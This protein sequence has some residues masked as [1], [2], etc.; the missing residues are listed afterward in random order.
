MNPTEKRFFGNY[1]YWNWRYDQ[2]FSIW[3]FFHSFFAKKPAVQTVPFQDSSPAAPK[4]N[5]AIRAGILI[6]EFT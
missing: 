6:R 3:K 5:Q 4:D 2:K 1:I